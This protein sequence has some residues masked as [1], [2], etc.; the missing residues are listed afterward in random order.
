[1]G[2]ADRCQGVLA[3]VCLPIGEMQLHVIG[4]EVRLSTTENIRYNGKAVMQNPICLEK[5][6]RITLDGYELTFYETLLEIQGNMEACSI[7]LTESKGEAERFEGFP[8]YKRSPRIIYHIEDEKIE[9]KAPPEQ[10]VF[11]KGSL[12]QMIV[13][14][15]S[16]AAFTVLMGIL[17]NRGPYVYMSLGMTLITLIFSVKNF[18]E[19]KK[20]MK[21]ENRKREE[22]YEA[23]LL[24]VRKKVRQARQKEREAL[25]Y[26]NPQPKALAGMVLRDSSRL[27]ER[28]LLDD[29][30]LQ[31]NLGYYEGKSHISVTFAKDDL[32]LSK[33][34]LVE[35]AKALTREY[36]KIPRIP[37]TVD[38]KKANLG[39]VG[40]RANVHEQLKYLLL[41]LTFFQSY[42]DLQIIFLHH[43]NYQEEF[44]YVRWYPHLKI[45]ALNVSGQISSEQARDQILGSIQ[46]ILKE[47]KQKLEEEKQETLFTP[48]FL[49]II[50]EPKLILNHAIMEYLQTG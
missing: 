13:P 35:D 30:F 11:S 34:E 10:K 7:L 36:A 44:S 50:D 6:D 5:G 38:L 19:Q 24:R 20:E 40:S 16:T 15:I 23:Y 18:L 33:D 1:M 17:M 39:L 9:V 47:R 2:N 48:Y 37:V 43:G 12:V 27:Y 8:Y 3:E 14:T 28:S 26:Q 41:Q 46:Q 25:D 4:N 42:K 32:E 45:H 22:I 49:F 29:D 31:V 21:E